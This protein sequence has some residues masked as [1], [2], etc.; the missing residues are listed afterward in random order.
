[1]E[2]AKKVDID[3]ASRIQKTARIVGVSIR[4][5]QRV[6]KGDQVN[7]EVLATYMDLLE[8]EQDAFESAKENHLLAAVEKLVPFNK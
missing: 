4:T 8:K 5:V 6:L 3:R 7:D 1:M 2:K